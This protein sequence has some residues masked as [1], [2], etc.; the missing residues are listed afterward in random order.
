MMHDAITDAAAEVARLE[1]ELRDAS[2]ALRAARRSSARNRYAQE[3]ACLAIYWDKRRALE[4][5]K[6]RLAGM[7]GMAVAA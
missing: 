1:R 5:A 6:E 3:G 7:A 4:A 2:D